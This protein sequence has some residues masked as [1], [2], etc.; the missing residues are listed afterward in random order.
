[1]VSIIIALAIGFGVCMTALIGTT[2]NGQELEVKAKVGGDL[3]IVSEEVNRSF[4]FDLEGIE[5]VDEAIAV[6][7][8]F[9]SMIAGDEYE[10]R[11]IVAFNS[12]E[13]REHIEVDNYFFIEGE[14]RRALDSVSTGFSVIV[15]EDIAQIYSLDLG[16]SVRIERPFFPS[17]V[18]VGLDNLE[19]K[20]EDLMVV[21]IVRA[22]PGL[23]IPLDEPDYY[24]WGN[25]IYL[26][27][28][29]LEQNISSVNSGWRFLVDVKGDSREV[30][31]EIME[32]NQGTFLDI[33][34]LKTELDEVNNNLSSRSILYLMFVNIGFLIIIITAG[35]GLIM[36]ISIGE[37]KNEFATIMARGAEG[38]QMGVLIMGEA[39]S[40]TLVGTMVGVFSGILTAYTF[41]RMLSANTLFG[42]SGGT[43][44]DRP[45][46]IPWYTILIIL[47]ALLALVITSALAAYKVKRIKLHTALRIRGG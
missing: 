7:S 4:E 40:I 47:I 19:F 14:S 12:S 23:E 43:L 3:Y 36:F 25:Q 2:V 46:V 20:S 13:Y 33:K 16:D 21:G 15:G 27:F 6:T 17:G 5:N 42:I 11:R 34:N 38:K 35:L 37:R 8:L 32:N 44:S 30:E 10:S 24:D 41:N 39:L 26:D 31:S 29:A 28:S 9:G 18:S 22:M 45:L 1:M